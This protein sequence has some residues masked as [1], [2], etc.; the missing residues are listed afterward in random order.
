MNQNTLNSILQGWKNF[1]FKSEKIEELANVRA[2]ICAGCEYANPEYPFKNY[3]PEEKRIE[4]IK[5]LGC[6]K[7]GCPL[8]SKLRSP[9]EKCPTEKW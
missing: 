5:G 9:F 3:L 8:S 6:D 7:C 4:I 2:V 1:I